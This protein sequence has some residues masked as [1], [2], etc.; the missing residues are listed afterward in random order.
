MVLQVPE[1]EALLASLPTTISLE[2]CFPSLHGLAQLKLPWKGL[3]PHL[4]ALSPVTCE[5]TDAAS[6]EHLIL[7]DDSLS[8]AAATASAG[9]SSL[10]TKGGSPT[11]G[12]TLV[13]FVIHESDSSLSATVC[14]SLSVQDAR[15]QVSRRSEAIATC[16][17][18]WL[19]TQLAGKEPTRD[20]SASANSRR[21]TVVRRPRIVL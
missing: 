8:S 16:V 5:W 15:S 14:S 3:F 9:A 1:T 12:R 6:N 18:C 19:W 21:H 7:V 11:D 13:H 10:A 2:E 20:R 4:I 17:A